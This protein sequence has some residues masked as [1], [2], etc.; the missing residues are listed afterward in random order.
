MKP[1]ITKEEDTFAYVYLAAILSLEDDHTIAYKN[2]GT[3]P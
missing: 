1:D 3:E 2:V